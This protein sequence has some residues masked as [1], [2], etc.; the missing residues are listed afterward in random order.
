VK[1]GLAR[2]G[3]PTV[4]EEAVATAAAAVDAADRIG[5]P[6]VLKL[7]STEVGHKSDLGLVKVGL[8]D[9]E[10]VHEAAT[11]IL[12]LARQHGVSDRR[13][14][15]QQLVAADTE[16]ILGMRRDPSFGPVI[17]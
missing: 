10:S 4:P 2:Y 8:R 3:V 16:L 13:L 17:V 12:S 6:V 14:V 7:L 1:Q 11:E 15:V 5:Y 9:A